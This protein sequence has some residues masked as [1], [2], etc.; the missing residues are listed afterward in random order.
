MNK[1]GMSVEKPAETQT[2]IRLASHLVR[3]PTGG[4]ISNPLGDWL[5]TLT[6]GGKT[7]GIR[8]FYSGRP[9]DPNVI[10]SCLTWSTLSVWLQ[11]GTSLAYSLAWQAYLPDAMAD[12]TSL[13]SS[14]VPTQYWRELYREA[15]RVSDYS[16]RLASHLVK[17]PNSLSEFESSVGL[18]WCTN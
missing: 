13:Y 1:E 8:F 17:V 6:K 3:V 18:V 11:L 12:D 15:C 10:M 9:V 2:S 4:Q 14:A 7:L 16:I 5:G